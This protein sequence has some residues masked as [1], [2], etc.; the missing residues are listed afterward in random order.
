MN[1]LVSVRQ[2]LAA[3]E[4]QKIEA[5]RKARADW[6][7]QAADWMGEIGTLKQHCMAIA[8]EIDE[9]RIVRPAYTGSCSLCKPVVFA[10][11]EFQR[12]CFA[13]EIVAGTHQVNFL[14]AEQDVLDSEQ[15][16]TFFGYEI[17]VK[18][19]A[20]TYVAAVRAT[21]QRLHD[22]LVQIILYALTNKNSNEAVLDRWNRFVVSVPE[23]PEQADICRE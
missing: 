18:H 14:T 19:T 2:E 13:V 9:S 5:D 8:L 12:H 23:M 15:G 7:V 10:D 16:G 17:I 6:A 1:F 21:A 11:F 3:I 4:A 22:G 20:R